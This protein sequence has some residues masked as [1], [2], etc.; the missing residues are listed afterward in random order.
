[1]EES[2]DKELDL[3]EKGNQLLPP[4][5]VHAGSTTHVR[6]NRTIEGSIAFGLFPIH[7]YMREPH[8]LTDL[9]RREKKKAQ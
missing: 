9:N 1:M 2:G 7:P 6:S 8:S 3:K 4:F 5:A